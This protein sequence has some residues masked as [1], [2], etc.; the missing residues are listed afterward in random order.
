MVVSN[1]RHYQCPNEDARLLQVV[2]VSSITGDGIDE[3]WKTM[4]KYVERMKVSVSLPPLIAP[5]SHLQHKHVTHLGYLVKTQCRP[6]DPIQ[7]I[8]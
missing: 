5:L 3:M 2:M 7:E 4:Q 6:C 1:F 8:M